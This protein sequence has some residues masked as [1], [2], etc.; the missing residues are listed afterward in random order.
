MFAVTVDLP[1]PP[2][3]EDMA[4]TFFMLESWFT[5]FKLSFFTAVNFIEKL[6]SLKK[7]SFKAGSNFFLRSDLALWVK[8]E[9]SIS[10]S[11]WLENLFMLRIFLW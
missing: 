8:F 3:A 11:T 6:I 2:L 1:T 10:I 4:I 9:T 5:L 7:I